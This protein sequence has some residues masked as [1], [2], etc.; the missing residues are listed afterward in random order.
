MIVVKEM[1]IEFL[2]LN[3]GVTG[4]ILLGISLVLLTARLVGAPRLF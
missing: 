3:A 1:P 2:V 4:V